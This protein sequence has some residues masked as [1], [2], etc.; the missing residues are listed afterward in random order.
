MASVA[1]YLS[2]PARDPELIDIIRG[3]IADALDRPVEQ[4]GA[5]DHLYDMLGLDSLGAAAVF[6]EL[7]YRLGIP[8]PDPNADLAGFHSA[9]LLASYVRSFEHHRASSEAT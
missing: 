5:D 3:F 8:E 1:K 9:R 4:V 6:I 2:L 7:S